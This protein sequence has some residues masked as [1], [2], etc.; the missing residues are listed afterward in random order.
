[1]KR[2]VLCLAALLSLLALAGCAG[3]PTHVDIVVQAPLN[4]KKG[5][6]F[7][8]VMR[9]T[10]ADAG[11]TQKLVSVDISDK[12][13]AGIHI[14]SAEPRYTE[15]SHIPIDNTVSYVFNLDLPPNQERVVKLR[16]TAVKAGDFG[17]GADFCINTDYTFLTQQL[18]TIVE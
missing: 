15:A 18:R 13:L 7:D 16:A 6:K 12:Y 2:R 14:E 8:I 11:R 17:G 1:M 5:E 4:V 9:V 10:N 3:D